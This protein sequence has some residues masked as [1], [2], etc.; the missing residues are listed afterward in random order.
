MSQLWI[1]NKPLMVAIASIVVIA[2]ITG[3]IIYIKSRPAVSLR[4]LFSTAGDCSKFSEDGS[5]IDVYQY[6]PNYFGR[7]LGGPAIGQSIFDAKL[8]SVVLALPSVTGWISFSSNSAFVGVPGKGI[9]DLHSSQL[10]LPLGS[11]DYWFSPDSRF[12]V[13]SAGGVYEFASGKQLVSLKDP[14]STVAFSP[15]SRYVAIIGSGN[16]DAAYDLKTGQQIYSAPRDKDVGTNAYWNAFFSADGKYLNV[17]SDGIYEMAAGRK[18]IPTGVLSFSPDSSLAATAIG[19]FDLAS[20]QRIFPETLAEG[21]TAYSKFSSDGKTAVIL[22]YEAPARPTDAIITTVFDIASRK[23]IFQIRTPGEG[24]DYFDAIFSPDGKSL[25]V[26]HDGVYDVATGRKRFSIDPKGGLSTYTTAPLS[27]SKDNS[28]LYVSDGAA[29]DMQTGRVRFAMNGDTLEGIKKDI[30]GDMIGVS[31]DGRLINDQVG[32]YDSATGIRLARGEVVYPLKG[33]EVA[34][35]STSPGMC[36]VYE[37]VPA[38]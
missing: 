10:V 36:T 16:V 7:G 27:F 14:A 21:T 5:L 24:R 33:N 22:T 9:Y 23:T 1:R 3:I 25:A 26:W 4:S 34:V 37:M 28:L 18:I 20:G 12:V 17:A 19:L 31:N 29:Y 38:R 32:V 30:F 11:R 15:D 8:G 6:P 2:M 35:S 13:A